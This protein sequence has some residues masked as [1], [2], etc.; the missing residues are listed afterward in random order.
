MKERE[1]EENLDALNNL[2]H[3]ADFHLLSR[4]FKSLKFGAK[5]SFE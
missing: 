2:C 5:S 3:G 1:I 4:S